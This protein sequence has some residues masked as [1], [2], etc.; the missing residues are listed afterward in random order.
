M[1]CLRNNSATEVNPSRRG[2]TSSDTSRVQGE[3]NDTRNHARGK[4][5]DGILCRGQG[6]CAALE[7]G[8]DDGAVGADVGEFVKVG[9]DAL[10][11]AGQQVDGV[12]NDDDA[13]NPGG[14]VDDVD[15]ELGV[16]GALARASRGAPEVGGQGEVPGLD[17]LGLLEAAASRGT[18]WLATET[19]AM[20]TGEAATEEMAARP[21]RRVDIENF[22]LDKECGEEESS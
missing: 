3:I 13:E 11:A 10:V 5:E 20:G 2:N 18:S 17:G 12:V 16:H 7:V 6:V 21:M 1:E 19:S 15:L 4:V 14:G 9:R 8:S 22:I